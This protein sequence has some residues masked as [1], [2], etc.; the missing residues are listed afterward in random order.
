MSALAPVL[1]ERGARLA[2]R[3]AQ[4]VLPTK[5]ERSGY[6]VWGLTALV[7]AI[8]EIWAAAEHEHGPWKTISQTVGLG[9]E[10][11]HTWVTLL[12][13]MVIVSLILHEA[14]FPRPPTETE[15]QSRESER[16]VCGDVQAA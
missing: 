2:R 9:L 7:V 4:G 13:V 8:P 6:I 14:R 5:R 1:A 15:D 12:V 11:D 3:A 16:S 10:R